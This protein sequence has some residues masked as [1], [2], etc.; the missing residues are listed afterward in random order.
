MLTCQKKDQMDNVLEFDFSLKGVDQVKPVPFKVIAHMTNDTV[1]IIPGKIDFGRIYEGT[2]SRVGVTL[3]NLS[4]LPQQL[5]FYPLPRE[6]SIDLDLIPI[7]LLPN[8]QL[9]TN[10]I[11]R[12]Q[13]VKG[14]ETRKDEGYLYCKI[15]TGNI[16]TKE[17]KIPYTTDILKCPLDF[18]A[19]RIDIQAL[20]IDETFSTS[21]KVTN[22][23]QHDILFEF[24]LPEHEI[25][26]LKINP[27]VAQVKANSKIDI[28]IE[29]TSKFRKLK[30]G[31]LEQ[32][33]KQ[34]EL[35]PSKN[36]QL[37]LKQKQEEEALKKQQ[38]LE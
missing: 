35:D 25:C 4:D 31:M 36:F 16:S 37:R 1:Q 21:V 6:I 5:V 30:A 32:I 33:R 12:S 19:K 22:I 2:G 10:L 9:D 23:T 18:Q 34:N 38:E 20:Q 15:I 3:N 8:E 29:Y 27:M 17:I 7:K 28:F 26:G 24:F 14:L 11:Y 13:E